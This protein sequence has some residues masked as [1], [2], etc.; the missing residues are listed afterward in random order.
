VSSAATSKNAGTQLHHL[1]P[2]LAEGSRFPQQV[3]SRLEA[4]S[5]TL[6][7]AVICYVM[8]FA[9][10]IYRFDR[11]IPMGQE[12]LKPPLLFLLECVLIGK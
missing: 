5:R 11:Q 12:D 1:I 3:H 8:L 10:Y 9:F 6:F 7:R 2:S 4:F